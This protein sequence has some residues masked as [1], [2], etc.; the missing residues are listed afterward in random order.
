MQYPRIY[1]VSLCLLTGAEWGKA[2]Y[3]HKRS[4]NYVLMLLGEY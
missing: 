4:F 1:L 2:V 3:S